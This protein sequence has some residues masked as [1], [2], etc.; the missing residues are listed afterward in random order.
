MTERAYRL[1][2]RAY[3][4]ALR[5]AH[6]EEMVSLVEDRAGDGEPWWRL[7]PALL[8]DTA[9]GATSSHWEHL[10]TTHRAIVLGIIGAVATLAAISDGPLTAL[11]V[12]I[13]AAVA[14]AFVLRWRPP[15]RDPDAPTHSWRR[16]GGGGVA[17][18]ACA[19]SAMA[20]IDREFTEIEWAVVFLTFVA[21]L[22]LTATGLA[23]LAGSRHPAG[24]S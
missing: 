24:T 1:L 2:L 10:M 3:P 11:P 21:G 15:V 22:F 16:W 5:N 13:I 23:L 6:G 19:V 20:L 18:L 14:I 12:L 4:R 7:W 8:S 9:R 17:L